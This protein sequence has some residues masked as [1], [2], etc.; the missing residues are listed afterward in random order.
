MSAIFF[1]YLLLL[2][3]GYVDYLTGVEVQ[4]G[5]LY[6]LVVASAAWNL[7]P[8]ALIIHSIMTCVVW[9]A[10]AGTFSQRWM[11][12]WNTCNRLGTTALVAIVFCIIKATLDKQ[13]QLIRELR[14]AS[15][16][17][18]RLKELLPVC[19]ICHTIQMGSEGESK[20]REFLQETTEID[21]LGGICQSCLQRR[22][23]RISEI[24]IDRYFSPK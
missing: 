6:L 1:C 15:L 12:Y 13:R 3:V 4:T 20:L 23:K 19:R 21:S 8:R 9:M 22:G 17:A 18:A 10:L 16:S 24:S 5:T 2:L 7:K 14:H 11:F